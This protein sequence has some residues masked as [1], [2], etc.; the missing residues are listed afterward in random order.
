MS[1]KAM[2]IA[3]LLFQL[4]CTAQRFTLTKKGLSIPYVFGQLKQQLD[5]DVIYV[6]RILDDAPLVD[7][8]A[9]FSGRTP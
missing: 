6:P 2:V 4:P 1:L 8:L 5:Y 7:Q 9:A 3:L